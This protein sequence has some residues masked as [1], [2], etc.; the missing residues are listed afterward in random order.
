MESE[1]T[2][3][4]QSHLNRHVFASNSNIFKGKFSRESHLQAFNCFVNNE[5]ER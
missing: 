3:N 1:H 2:K 4:N 5:T